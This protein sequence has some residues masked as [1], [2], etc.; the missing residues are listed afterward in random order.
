M[1]GHGRPVGLH[2]WSSSGRYTASVR[3]VLRFVWV[4]F[5]STSLLTCAARIFIPSFDRARETL[6]EDK[7][8]DIR[9]G[10][11]LWAAIL[12]IPTIDL[13]VEMRKRSAPPFVEQSN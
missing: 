6:P 3:Y 12:L 4:T 11:Y 5:L 10:V 9:D 7:P 1:T 8:E 13:I 2:S